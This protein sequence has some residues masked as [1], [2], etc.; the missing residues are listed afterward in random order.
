MVTADIQFIRLFHV[1]A[2]C[3]IAEAVMLDTAPA[4][5][6]EQQAIGGAA[7]I[8]VEGIILH[9]DV[10]GIHHRHTGAVAAETVIRICIA[11][12]EHK[13]QAV[14][15]I[16]KAFVA[17]DQAVLGKLEVH[18]VAVA[19]NAVAVYFYAIALP[20]MYSVTGA[21]LIPERACYLVIPYEGMA[22][23]AQVNGEII[24]L[25][26]VVLNAYVL[27]IMN[28]Q[29]GHVFDAASTGIPEDKALNKNVSTG[30][31]HHLYFMLSIYHRLV[32]TYKRY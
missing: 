22:R 3:I 28:G 17:R 15:G 14:A 10:L 13:V 26:D 11:V 18:A 16:A 6:F 25:E 30:H 4:N 19:G 24:V 21:S 27:G 32:L 9:A 12:A 5:A 31:P 2:Y 29:R 20:Q 1:Y 8:A 23:T 7:P